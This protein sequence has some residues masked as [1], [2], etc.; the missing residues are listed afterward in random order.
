[1]RFLVDACVDVRVRDWLR[2]Q[3][4]DANHLRDEG[5]QKLP[6]GRIFVKAS[7]EARFIVT[8]D[9]DFGEIL[10]LAAD[11]VVSTI[12][13]RLRDTRAVSLIARLESVLPNVEP[14]LFRGVIVIIEPARFRVRH[15]PLR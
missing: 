2:E 1:M 14:D 15:L 11:R 4:H 9:L 7:E 3:G 10:A 13:F 5:L 8:L 6:N 12:V